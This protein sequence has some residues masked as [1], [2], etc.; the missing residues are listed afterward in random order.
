MK[1]KKTRGPHIYFNMTLDLASQLTGFSKSKLSTKQHRGEVD[2]H[3]PEK[4]I[5]FLADILL[6]NR[7]RK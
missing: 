1:N 7:Y 4:A 3:D 5:L 2:F 6:K